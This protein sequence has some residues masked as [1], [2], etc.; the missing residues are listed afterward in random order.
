MHWS[1]GIGSVQ[2]VDCLE[3]LMLNRYVFLKAQSLN[4]MISDSVIPAE[5]STRSFAW[6]KIT[7]TRAM[8]NHIK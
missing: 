3:Q 2:L 8:K 1:D 5:S 7:T 6:D 4:K